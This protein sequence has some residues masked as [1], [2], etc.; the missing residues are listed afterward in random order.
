MNLKNDTNHGVNLVPLKPSNF[1]GGGTE[2]ES[3][4][5]NLPPIPGAVK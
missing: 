1:E 2:R 5:P 3:S 4:V